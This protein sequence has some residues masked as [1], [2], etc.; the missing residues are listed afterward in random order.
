MCNRITWYALWYFQY[1]RS[2]IG[3]TSCVCLYVRAQE[4][5]YHEASQESPSFSK[6]SKPP[7]SQQTIFSSDWS[8]L[9]INLLLFLKQ[10]VSVFSTSQHTE[11]LFCWLQLNA[12]ECPFENPAGVSLRCL[13]L[14]I[15]IPRERRADFPRGSYWLTFFPRVHAHLLCSPIVRR[16]LKRWQKMEQKQTSGITKVVLV[17]CTHGPCCK[18]VFLW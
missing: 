9:K 1:R 15:G 18:R 7:S 5:P 10:F 4:H 13:P 14:K 8:P 16:F 6:L 17:Q 12:F 2:L 11:N 3:N